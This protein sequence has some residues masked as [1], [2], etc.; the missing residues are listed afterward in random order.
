[1]N[2]LNEFLRKKI[3]FSSA[4]TKVKLAILHELGKSRE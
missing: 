4:N 3:D 1:M 2:G